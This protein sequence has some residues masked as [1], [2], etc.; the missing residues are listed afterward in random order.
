MGTITKLKNRGACNG[1]VSPMVFD[2]YVKKI[3]DYFQPQGIDYDILFDISIN[4]QLG[5][6]IACR[7]SVKYWLT[8]FDID[9]SVLLINRYCIFI[10][11][12][13][14]I[15]APIENLDNITTV[16]FDYRDYDKKDIPKIVANSIK[17]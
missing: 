11:G 16:I 15:K 8:R 7:S 9:T 2:A 10:I 14:I 3:R 5:V 1:T 4:K 6:P 12:C 17:R 13:G